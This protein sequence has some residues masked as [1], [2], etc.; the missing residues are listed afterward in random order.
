MWRN[1]RNWR[2]RIV[3][4][5]GLVVLSASGLA[6]ARAELP[7]LPEP[8]VHDQAGL[9]GAADLPETGI[10]GDV[11]R[12]DQESGRAEQGYNCGLSLVGHA[13]LDAEGRTP[14]GNANMAWAGHCAYVAGRG[15]LFADPQPL[16]GDGVAVIDVADPTNPVHVHTLRTPGALATSE[17]LHAVETPDRSILVVGQY[18]NALPGTTPMDVYDVTDCANPV[19]VESYTWP[20][21]T[22]N[23]TISGNGRYVFATQP[24]QVVDISP[25][26]DG[27]PAT[28]TIY[29]GNLD[30]EVPA[31]LLAPDP[32]ADV[33]DLLPDAVTGVS[34]SKYLAHEAWPSADGTTLYVGGQLPTFEVLSILDLTAWLDRATGAPAGPPVV[35]SQRSGRGHS[36]RTGTIRAD[37]GSV[38]RRILLHSEESVFG[39]A[40]GCAPDDLNPFAGPAQPWLTDITDPEDPVELVQFGLAINDPENCPTQLDSGTNSSVHY[41]DVDDPDDTT[42]VMASMWNAGVR[43]FD[44]R[45][46]ERPVEVAYFNPA[47]VLAG[48][49][50]VLDQAWGHVR[51]VPE[52]GQ[53]WYAS[54]NG[55]FWVLELEPQVR[56]HLGLDGGGTPP[57]HPDGAPGTGG[58]QLATEIALDD[59]TWRF[60]CTLAPASSAVG[61]A[62]P[63]ISARVALAVA[64][65]GA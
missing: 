26:W 37:D 53:I 15:E 55:G 41:H 54:A 28:G 23:L 48:A 12:A 57:H 4:V 60:S 62:P 42:F 13:V 59:A 11:P 24:L 1:R 19:L 64:A 44:V 22:H 51:W 49:G 21:N 32:V 5:S 35:I 46:P 3:A 56:A 10:Q 16:P 58:V 29:L 38:E 14:T 17:A 25:L 52:T 27:D 18:G 34:R 20:E 39:M 30:D 40:Y 65:A 47:D 33:D 50:V 43:V 31:P 6:D 36:V 8:V 63:E 45:D 61:A 9:C 2:N 7:L